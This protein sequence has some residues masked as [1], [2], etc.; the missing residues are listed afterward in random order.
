ML[1]TL[2]YKEGGL[3]LFAISEADST[4]RVL[5][6]LPESGGFD[7][8][9]EKGAYVMRVF[10]DLDRNRIWKRDTEPASDSLRVVLTPGGVLEDV[11]FVLQRPPH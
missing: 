11:R 5:Y 10:R 2:G 1:D 6:E 7:L 8:Q 3:R 4:R 9:F